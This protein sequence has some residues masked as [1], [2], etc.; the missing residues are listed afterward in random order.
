LKYL[1][2][3]RCIVKTLKFLI[4][5]LAVVIAFPS[6]AVAYGEGTTQGAVRSGIDSGKI[7]RW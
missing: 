7:C 2:K 5:I 6:S 4:V 1:N 3:G